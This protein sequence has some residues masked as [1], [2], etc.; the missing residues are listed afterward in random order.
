MVSSVII[1]HNVRP[2]GIRELSS[3]RIRFRLA[4]PVSGFNG[5]GTV[6]LKP[7]YLN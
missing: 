3:T 4:G 6:F 2:D 7:L 1:V 5:R